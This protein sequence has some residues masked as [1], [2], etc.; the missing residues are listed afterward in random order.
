MNAISRE[1][2]K[3]FNEDQLRKKVLIPLYQAL[4]YHDVAEY[5]GGYEDGKDIVATQFVDGEKVQTVIVAKS[6]SILAAKE[7]ARGVIFAS[8]SNSPIMT[9]CCCG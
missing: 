5:H 6:G 4:G 8:C 3:R 2:L 1:D 7:N 9:V